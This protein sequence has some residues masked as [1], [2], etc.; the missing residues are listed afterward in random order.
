MPTFA[1]V[2]DYIAA[3]SADAQPRLRELRT[4]VRAAIPGAAEGISYGM[5]TYKFPGGSVHFAAAKQHCALYGSFVHAFADELRAFDT[6][7]GTVR[8]P[9]DKPI[10]ETLVHRLIAAKVAQRQ[11]ARR[12]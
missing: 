1:T 3:Q 2:D 12:R 6:S 11:A 5:P 7:K 10:P 8:F 4:I 9:L